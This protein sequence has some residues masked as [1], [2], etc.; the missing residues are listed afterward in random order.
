[1]FFNVLLASSCHKNTTS[2]ISRTSTIFT[3]LGSEGGNKKQ[4]KSLPKLGRLETDYSPVQNSSV[5]T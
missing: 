3:P 1:M 4:K 2:K 5:A